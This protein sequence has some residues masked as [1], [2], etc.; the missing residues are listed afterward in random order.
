M[1][2]ADRLKLR[3]VPTR[4]HMAHVRRRLLRLEPELGILPLLAAGDRAA[5]DVGANKGAYTWELLRIAPSVHAFEPNPALLPWLSRLRDPRLTIHALALGARDG[6]AVL[7]VPLGRTGRPS[8]QG[9]TLA[10]TER[11]LRGALEVAAQVRR[12]DSLDLGD[13]GFIKIDVEGFEAEVIEGAHETIARCRPVMLIE[14]EAAHTGEPSSA[15]IGRIAGFGYACY[16]LVD[17]VL[18]DWRAVDLDRTHVFN[19]IFLPQ[20]RC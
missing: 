9:A 4:W 13:V 3:L 10:A 11:T 16:G 2:L 14:I 12:L 17:G 19:W 7:K 8:K 6:E 20:G 15:M 1:D 5:L 18:T